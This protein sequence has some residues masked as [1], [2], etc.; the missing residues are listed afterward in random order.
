MMRSSMLVI[1]GLVGLGIVGLV[2]LGMAEAWAGA[3]ED[4]PKPTTP[5]AGEAKPPVSAVAVLHERYKSGAEQ[6]RELER[7]RDRLA[8]EAQSVII[9]LKELELAM[10]QTIVAAWKTCGKLAMGFD[11]KAW[12]CEAPP[13]AKENKP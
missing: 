7:Q 11:E 2:G 5:V 8:L 9:K 13:P 1:V 3:A 4:P 10:E 6:R 12:V